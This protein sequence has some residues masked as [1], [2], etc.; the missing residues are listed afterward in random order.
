MLLAQWLKTIGLD[1]Y[2][3]KL[4][5]FGVTTIDVVVTLQPGDFDKIGIASYGHRVTLLAEARKYSLRANIGETNSC[6]GI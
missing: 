6:V 3:A 5:S 1:T 2:K 4:V